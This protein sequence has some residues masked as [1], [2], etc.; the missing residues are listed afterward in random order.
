M[1]TLFQGLALLVV[2]AC[3]LST[4][5][6]DAGFQITLSANGF[7][8]TIADGDADD[9]DSDANEIRLIEF[10]IG[11]AGTSGIIAEI[12]TDTTNTP[13][14]FT[15]FIVS[16]SSFTGTLNAGSTLEI[17]INGTGFTSPTTPPAL[18]AMQTSTYNPTPGGNAEVDW[19]AA[20]Y[21]DTSDTASTSLATVGT[22]II[23]FTDTDT[24][25]INSDDSAVINSLSTTPYAL[26][27]YL[28]I[29]PTNDNSTFNLGSGG[30]S[31][32]A[33]GTLELT[34]VPEPASMALLGLGGLLAGAGVMRRKRKTAD[35]LAV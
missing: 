10:E 3:L 1:K 23:N 32:S 29:D 11:G 6:A 33:D 7:S 27:L 14:G 31:T 13:G 9:D 4:N 19:T 5:S 34:P 20:S 28:E 12:S 17:L 30:E 35:E 21:Y 15:A 22:N 8:S 25:T 26:N 2:T 24:G 16:N 18:S